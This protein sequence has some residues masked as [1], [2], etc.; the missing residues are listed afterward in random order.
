MSLRQCGWWKHVLRLVIF[1]RFGQRLWPPNVRICHS[2]SDT[3]SQAQNIS[4][5]VFV[6]FYINPILWLAID[7]TSPHPHSKSSWWKQEIP[8]PEARRGQLLVGLGVWVS[9]KCFGA[10]CIGATL[11]MKI[12]CPV[13]LLIVLD[14][15]LV[16]WERCL[17][18]SLIHFDELLLRCIISFNDISGCTRKTRIIDVVYNASNNELVRTK[19]LVKNC[20]VLVD[21]TPYRQWFES[22]Y[23]LPLGRTNGA[24]LVIILVFFI[25]CWVS[26]VVFLWW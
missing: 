26:I 3:C 22:H 10:A 12:I 8:C 23:A 4:S 21:S 16:R 24:K 7:W 2:Y 13:L 6:R 14:G 15:Y 11:S 25:N 18:W 19:T 20:I 5:L 17:T 1:G 9:D